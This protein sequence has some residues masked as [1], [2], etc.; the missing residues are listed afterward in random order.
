MSP[1]LAIMVGSLCAICV[2]MSAA[3]AFWSNSSTS[4]H[5]NVISANSKVIDRS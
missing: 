2:I 1:A 3:S 4:R 5:D